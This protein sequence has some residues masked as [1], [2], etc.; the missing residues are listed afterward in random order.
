[1]VA[2]VKV[3]SNRKEKIVKDYPSPKTK[4]IIFPVKKKDDFIITPYDSR[5]EDSGIKPA[6]VHKKGKF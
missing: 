3:I 5:P 6:K 4:K 2:Y 1:M